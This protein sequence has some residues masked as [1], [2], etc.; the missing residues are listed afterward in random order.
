MYNL[1]TTS[2]VSL[3]KP[4]HPLYQMIDW[5]QV[6]SGKYAVV[7]SDFPGLVMYYTQKEF[8]MLIIT[9]KQKDSSVTILATPNSEPESK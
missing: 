4:Q 1:F 7:V 8:N 6:S 2:T 5:E 3:Q 9:W